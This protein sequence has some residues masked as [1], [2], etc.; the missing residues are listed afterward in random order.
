M[1][2]ET[3]TVADRPELKRYEIVIG[4]QVA[5]LTYRKNDDH[6]LLSHTEVPE[7]L[8]GR[9]LG[10]VL[11]KHGLD[12]ARRAG[13]QVIVR[14]PFV[15][16]WLLRHKEYND[17]VVARVAESGAVDRQPPPTGEPR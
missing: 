9:G 8:R 17:I 16:A 3:L 13:K 14:C 12:E 7:S 11:A 4:D 1:P 15:T 6:V 10:G 2:D 5:Y